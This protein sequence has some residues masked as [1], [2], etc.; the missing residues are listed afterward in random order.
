MTTFGMLSFA[1]LSQKDILDVN[2]CVECG[3]CTDNCPANAIG[4]SLDPKR[5]VLQMQRGLLAGGDRI[6]GDETLVASGEAWVSEQDLYQCLTCGAC[7]EACPVGIEHVGL[8]ILD[9]RRGLVSEGRTGSDKLADM[10]TTMERSP[11]NAWG[12]SQQVRRKL[13]ANEGPACLR[14]PRRVA[15]LAWVR[16]QFRS[17]RSGRGPVDAAY[18]GQRRSLVGRARERDVLR[19]AGPENR[20]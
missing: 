1:D 20:Q 14:A 18:L 16:L 4:G 17:A 13:V 6:A 11:H 12:V 8:K 10:F 3:R 2:S 5:I 19:G 9:L 7:E 15:V